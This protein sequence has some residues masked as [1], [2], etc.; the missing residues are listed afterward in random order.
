MHSESAEEHDPDEW[1]GRDADG[2]RRHVDGHTEAP[3]PGGQQPAHIERAEGMER[4][5][6]EARGQRETE[7]ERKA[8]DE[9]DDGKGDRGPGEG[10]TGETGPEAVRNEPEQRL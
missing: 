1:S 6:A 8:V 9:T 4:T 7:Q 5:R 2:S 10:E 3:P